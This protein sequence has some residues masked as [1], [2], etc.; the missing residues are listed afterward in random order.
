MKTHILKL[1]FTFDE[2]LKKNQSHHAHIQK[3]CYLPLNLT[4][5]RPGRWD[6]TFFSY[7]FEKIS[8]FILRFDFIVQSVD[9]GIHDIVLSV[10]RSFNENY[11]HSSIFSSIMEPKMWKQKTRSFFNLD[12]WYQRISWVFLISSKDIVIW[13]VSIR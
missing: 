6:K 5:A 9:H 11:F 2:F 13:N 10:C 7:V 1:Y 3:S 8:P 4:C 12:W